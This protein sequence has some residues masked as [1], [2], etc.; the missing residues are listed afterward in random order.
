MITNLQLNKTEDTFNLLSE[1]IPGY[2]KVRA[3]NAFGTKLKS[4]ADFRNYAFEL[5]DAIVKAETE[6]RKLR[7]LQCSY[8]K[9]FPS[10]NKNCLTTPHVLYN[11]IRSSI[12][13]IRD[14]IKKFCPKNRR[15]PGTYSTCTQTFS[16]SFLCNQTPYT[17]DMY[18]D[19]YPEYVKNVLELLEKYFAV[20]TEN[21]LICKGMI[22][23]EKEIRNNDEYL[24][25]IDLDCQ[26]LYRE[27]AIAARDGGLLTKDITKEQYKKIVA[28][29]KSIKEYR[30][31]N[32]HNISKKQYQIRVFRNVIMEGI[33]NGLS[34]EE[35]RIWTD[36]KEC[37]FVK[38]CVRPA[39]N[40]MPKRKDL[41]L[42]KVKNS[43]DKQIRA[44]YIACFMI[45]C[46]VSSSH[47]SDFVNY[48]NQKLADA[49]FRIP[50]YKSITAALR[51]IND[52]TKKKYMADFKQYEYD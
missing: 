48:L 42:I 30:R 51:R 43:T 37:D 23:E 16:S 2:N 39:I 40:A 46:Q 34:S 45:W 14:S 13:E 1:Y 24:E 49:P 29:T 18:P 36:I 22:D 35:S 11:T 6:Q 47:Y 33:D 52:K 17:P 8:N 38:E 9:T 21:I 19:M 15:A 4:E 10:D 26:E 28:E 25:Q 27:M 50:Q 5:E 44:D 20:A 32:Y 12:I 31:E 41:P 7:K 3:M